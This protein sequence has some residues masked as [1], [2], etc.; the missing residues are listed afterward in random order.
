MAA[1]QLTTRS[2]PFNVKPKCP[3]AEEPWSWSRCFGLIAPSS[4]RRAGIRSKCYCPENRARSGFGVGTVG[5]GLRR[6]ASGKRLVLLCLLTVPPLV[7]QAAS[8]EFK[9]AVS[10]EVSIFIGAEPEPPFKHAVSREVSLVVNTPAVPNRIDRL[11]L[12][13]SPSGEAVELSWASYNQW[14]EQDVIGYDVYLAP[15]GFTNVTGMTPYLRIPGETLSY[16]VS[17][18]P[19]WQDHYFAVVPVDAAGGF[20]P[21]VNP[22]GAYMIAREVISR[23]SSVF[24]GVE[25]EAA[26]REVIS[27][28]LSIFI[29][30]EPEPPYRQLVSREVSVLQPHGASFF[31]VD[32]ERLVLPMLHRY[33]AP[34]E[35]DG[36]VRLRAEGP[37]SVLNLPN[38]TNLVGNPRPNGYLHIEA[39]AGGRV[40]LPALLAMT[41]PT[42]GTQ[43]SA[44]RGIRVLADGP[45]SVVDLTALK[46]L[47]DLAHTPGTRFEVRNGGAI[48]LPGLPEVATGAIAFVADGEDSVIDL[49]RLVRL[50]GGSLEAA[51][52]GVIRTPNLLFADRATL[53][54]RDAG[55]MD[56][57]QLRKLTNSRVVADGTALTFAD[58]FDWTGTVFE[59]PNGGRINLPQIDFGLGNLTTSTNEL[60]CGDRITVSWEGQNRTGAAVLGSWTDAVYLSTDD[61]WDIDDLLLGTADQTEGLGENAVYLASAQVFVPGMLPGDYHLIVRSVAYQLAGTLGLENSVTLPV[62]LLMPELSIGNPIG[63]EFLA[64]RHARYWRLVVEPDEDLMVTLDLLSE[65]GATELYLREGAIPTRSN[66]DVKYGAAFQSD[67]FVRIPGTWASTNYVLAY[68]A[69]IESPP[70]AFVVAPQYLGLAAEEAIPASG[71]NAGHVTLRLFGSGLS[72]DTSLR[73]LYRDS[74]GLEQQITAARTVHVSMG[75]IEST[76]D[77]SGLMPG[78]ADLMVFDST[79]NTSR[80]REP[81]TIESGTPPDLRLE[82]DEVSPARAGPWWPGRYDVTIRNDSNQDAELV[83]LTAVTLLDARVALS[84]EG[85]GVFRGG[86][87]SSQGIVSALIPRLAPRQEF[88]VRYSLLV[89]GSYEESEIFL[90]WAVKA[91][92]PGRFLAALPEIVE[93]ARQDV[94]ASPHAQAIVPDLYS[95]AGDSEAWADAYVELLRRDGFLPLAASRGA[96]RMAISPQAPRRGPQTMGYSPRICNRTRCFQRCFTDCIWL[97]AIACSGAVLKGLHPELVGACIVLSYRLCKPFCD[98]WCDW[99]CIL[100][101]ADPNDIL[102]PGGWGDGQF[103]P[104]GRPLMYTVRFENLPD[105]SA[106]A[107]EVNVANRLE[108]DL[109]W[110]SVEIEEIGFA[111]L[112]VIPPT[113]ASHYEGRTTFDG[114]TWRQAEG[115]QRGLTPLMVDV[116][117]GVDPRSGL[118]TLNLRSSD[119][120]T[121]TFPA[122][123]YAGFLPPNRPELF[124]HPTNETVCCG[125]Q[126][127]T[128]ALVHPGEGYITYTVRPRAGVPT[129]T[130]VTNAAQ[131]VF[132]WND[133]IDTP[134]VFNTIDAGAPFSAVQ[135]LPTE[136]GP[137]FLVAWVGD[138]DAGGTGVASVDVWVSVN[139]GPYDRWLEGTS[140]RSAWF[141]GDNGS[142]YSFYSVARDWVGNTEKLPLT[143]DAITTVAGSLRL[144]WRI[145]NDHLVL[146][147]PAALV[148]AV[149]EAAAT[150]QGPYLPV[151]VSPVVDGTTLQMGLSLRGNSAF[152]RLRL[153]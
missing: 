62:T 112:R 66:F 12:T 92:D 152:F 133:P 128:N 15:T 140:D 39:I 17:G 91:M 58:L 57:A 33:E 55:R 149:V 40:E 97:R 148:T 27:R 125:F 6:L 108:G 126:I 87:Q 151:E 23:E 102:G 61:Q 28:E 5:R 7:T 71:G 13:S 123:A 72:R 8:S 64:P 1:M 78:Q 141:V 113:R 50:V 60:W 67:Q 86:L 137:A 9:E 63:S 37:G 95:A 24:V 35:A 53:I 109:D 49:S 21:I 90:D 30:A 20:D 118:L 98:T 44:P 19:P 25:P 88:T 3:P 36:I 119:V 117:A 76:F 16:A 54:V 89:D 10:R 110:T 42:D 41:Q 22:S 29:G 46:H 105:A 138:D 48:L 18:L 80:L 100:R 150:L 96:S 2:D 73:L 116:K 43:P 101:A 122:D 103:V 120:D 68:A 132:D 74:G 52:G 145:E 107:L 38:L 130:V 131:I 70:A 85:P 77:L 127:N 93:V 114:W 153:R 144:N 26:Y 106:A 99:I 139:D 143:P 51:R 142:T 69:D 115:W 34:A 104:G 134:V 45:G 121:G 79:G 82:V 147:W 47:R 31:V 135:P 4:A 136:S 83:I 14:A 84:V 65:T 59:S 11:S 75:E 111:G 94:L 81:F 129:G 32:G 56:I 124:Y 146:F